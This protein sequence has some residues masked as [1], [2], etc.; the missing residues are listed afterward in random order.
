[1]NTNAKDTDDFHTIHV[2]YVNTNAKD[3]NDFNTVLVRTLTQRTLLCEHWHKDT[4]DFN[5]VFVVWTLAQRTLTISTLSLW[6][7]WHKWHFCVNTDAKDTSALNT[8]LVW[9]LTQRA[10]L[11]EHWH[12]GHFCVNTGTCGSELQMCGPKQEKCE[13]YESCVCIAGISACRC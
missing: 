6:E 2:S 9:T 12:K 8:V 5:T 11:C 4:S 13:S 1:M 3:T 7:H 10:Y